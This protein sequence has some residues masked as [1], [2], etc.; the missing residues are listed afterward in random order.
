VFSN[1][2]ARFEPA[3]FDGHTVPPSKARF[4]LTRA[5]NS[6][7]FP[8]GLIPSLLGQPVKLLRAS[9]EIGDCVLS[10]DDDRRRRI[11]APDR[12]QTQVRFE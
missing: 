7:A 2:V 10:G 4:P 8:H 9:D 3:G 1:N 5:G 6:Y 11:G 12:R